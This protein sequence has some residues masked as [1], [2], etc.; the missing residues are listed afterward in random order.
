MAALDHATVL[1]DDY[2]I[3]AQDRRQPVGD[4]DRGAALQDALDGRQ[5]KSY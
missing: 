5:D 3:G 1:K 4:G 2:Q